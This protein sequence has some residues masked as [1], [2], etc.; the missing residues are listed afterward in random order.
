MTSSFSLQ[1]RDRSVLRELFQSRVMTLAHIALL[2]F[3]RSKESAKKR[4]QKMKAQGLVGERR[5]QVNEPGIL[6]LTRK[7][8]ELLLQENQ[9]AH[10]P[11]LSVTAFLKRAD[12]SA[13]TIRH[14]LEVMDVKAALYDAM[15]LSDVFSIAEFG[16]W[17]RL[18]EFQTTRPLPDGRSVLVK[19]DGFIRIH[20]KET[21]G[22][23]SEHTFFLEVDRSTE[24]QSVLSARASCYLN[25]YK[26]GGFA[27]RNGA[28]RTHYKEFPF[29][30]LFVLKNAERRNNT[31]EQLLQCNPPILTMVYLSTKS[32]VLSNPAGPIWVRPSDYRD[33]VKE[34]QF[35]GR[36]QD[37]V[38]RRQSERERLVD[39]SIQK[40]TLFENT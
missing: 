34:T 37:S 24:S 26:S 39:N 32:E 31:A 13:L 40:V 20:E 30:V 29:R 4:L 6:F 5:R 27:I 33:T 8:F 1:E 22:A 36:A 11:H 28:S 19:P 15:R 35:A 23:I 25:Y 10:L 3:E 18:H 16:T 38:Y 21:A 12:V 17:P 2:F 7:G 14:E 9:I